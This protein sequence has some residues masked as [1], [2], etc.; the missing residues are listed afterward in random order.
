VTEGSATYFINGGRDLA[1]MQ[2]DP[3]YA[4]HRT[5]RAQ[6]VATCE[7]LLRDTLDGKLAGDAYDRASHR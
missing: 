6:L 4:T 5:D 3:T 7:Q 2:R 1:V